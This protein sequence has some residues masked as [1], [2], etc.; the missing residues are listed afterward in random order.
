MMTSLLAEYSYVRYRHFCKY[1]VQKG[2]IF[3]HKYCRKTATQRGWKN[4]GSRRE[5]FSLGPI[6]SSKL[7]LETS[8][9]LPLRHV[10]LDVSP[11]SAVCELWLR[12]FVNLAILR[13][14]LQ[15]ADKIDIGVVR[16]EKRSKT[17]SRLDTYTLNF[18]GD[19]EL[20]F[21]AGIIAAS[22]LIVSIKDLL[23]DRT[24]K[25]LSRI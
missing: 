13:R 7:F 15:T 16:R 24:D 12:L 19:M 2:Q 11:E 18:P 25:I 3:L 6:N 1:C 4:K 5:T 21:K 23:I 14:Q 17:F 20:R 9:L 22:I 10:S 8:L